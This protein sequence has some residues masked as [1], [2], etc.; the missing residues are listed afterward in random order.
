MSASPSGAPEGAAFPGASLYPHLFSPWRIRMTEV[1]NRIVFPPT[2]P[3]WVSDPWRGLFTDAAVAY[4]EERARAGVGLIIIGATHVHPDSLMAPLLMPQLFDDENIEPL[5]RIADAVHAHGCRLGIQLWHSGMRGSPGIKQ[6]PS[7]DYHATWYTMAPSQVPLGEFPGGTT[8]KEMS[9]AEI[10]EALAAYAAAG[11][12]AI[13]AGLD[14]V[15]LHLSHGYLAWQFLSPLY[16]KRQDDW[17]GSYDKRLRFPVEALRRIRAAVG[18]E[19]WVGFRIN[20]TSFWP[21]D[22]ELEDVAQVVQDLQGRTDTDYVNV[23]AGVHHSFIH[24]PMEFE[25][26]W[27]KG[28]ARRIKEVSAKPVLLVGRITTPEVAE[29]LL[30]EE[31]G[32]AICLARQLFADADWARKAAEG[33]SWDI[34]RCVAANHCWRSVSLGGRVQCVYNPTVGRERNWGHGT[35]TPVADPKRALVIGAGPAGL[36]YA[37]VA[38]ARGHDVVV[39]EAEADP[40]GH[41]RLE[42]LLPSRAEYGRIAT[43]LAD[44]AMGNGADLHTATRVEEASLDDVLATHRPDHVVLATG[45]AIRAD[46]FQGWTGEPLPGWETARCVGWDQVATGAVAPT[47]DVV[48]VDDLC[49]AIAPLV[50]VALAQ[51]GAASTRIV[52]RWPMVAMDTILDVY[53]EWLMPKLYGAGVGLV[54]DHFVRGMDGEDLHLFNVHAPERE[55]TLH[56]DWVVMATART[57]RTELLAPLQDRGVSVET[58]GSATAPRG[59]YEAV[60]EGHRQARLL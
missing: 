39:L 48:V 45:A 57:S 15:E 4:Y 50:A 16:N 28:Y 43:W 58:I 17:G 29:A 3:S 2:C 14:G 22:L 25:A 11:A 47:G 37:R 26:G 38:A 23:S 1:K 36:E 42:S 20:S 24:T 6:E 41:V 34:R 32:D 60:Y 53:L 40:G 21:G 59:T 46:G 55:Q 52:T 12:R 5:R 54:P 35:L 30:A 19:P 7:Y 51:G 33:R 18:E 44:Q 8:P 13:R 31:Q 9:E 10:E 27:E 49:N 56:A